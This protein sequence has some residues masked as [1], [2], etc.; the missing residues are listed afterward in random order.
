KLWTSRC[1]LLTLRA[2]C[3]RRPSGLDHLDVLVL[4]PA[5]GDLG[6]V[7]ADLGPDLLAVA[8]LCGSDAVVPGGDPGAGD[9]LA[10]LVT[11]HRCERGL[12]PKLADQ[13]GVLHDGG[14]ERAP[15]GEEH[16]ERGA[17]AVDRDGLDLFAAT[18]RLD[19]LNGARDQLVVGSPDARYGALLR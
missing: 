5:F 2:A 11:V 14:H 15:L 9:R 19:G 18:S 6:R 13:L 10:D 4:C 17:V 8:L 7:E 3:L 16:V 1:N 12:R